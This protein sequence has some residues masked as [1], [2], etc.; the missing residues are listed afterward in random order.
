METCSIFFPNVQQKRSVS[1]TQKQKLLL[2]FEIQLN[3]F[4]RFH[5]NN[6]YNGTENFT[7]LMDALRN[8]RIRKENLTQ[9]ALKLDMPQRLLYH[10]ISN[11]TPQIKRYFKQFDLENIHIIFFDE[12]KS[13]FDL[14]Y[15]KLLKF[16]GLNYSN[17][18]LNNIIVNHQYGN[19]KNKNKVNKFPIFRKLVDN[20]PRFISRLSRIF[21][22]NKNRSK[23]YRKIIMWNTSFEERK[24]LSAEDRN[25]LIELCKNDVNALSELLNKNLS[26]W[27]N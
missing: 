7:Q 13:N 5:A 12:L 22:N 27:L 23:I 16:L 26:H 20:P 3:R 25:Y 18:K 14:E 1:L 24:L 2:H 19:P 4:I 10:E 8:E 21:L 11:Y 6:V 17:P 9:L 15:K